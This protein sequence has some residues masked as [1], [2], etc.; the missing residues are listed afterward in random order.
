MPIGYLLTT[1]LMATFVML[2]I[3][4]HRPRRSSPFRL[5]YVFGFLFNWPLV[6]FALLAA[7]TAL[8]I[9]QSGTGSAVW[10]DL[11]LKGRALRDGK[12]VGSARVSS[13]WQVVGFEPLTTAARSYADTVHIAAARS[14]DVK[15]RHGGTRSRQE[16]DVEIWCVDGI[17]IVAATYAF[18]FYEDG[19]QVGQVDDFD[20]WLVS[21]TVDGVAVD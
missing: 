20:T 1:G 3:S 21:A 9:A 13:Q 14:I 7:S 11:K 6:A 10:N 17:G 8:A 2:A 19:R 5:S 16:S 4:R 12:K 15:Q 18:R